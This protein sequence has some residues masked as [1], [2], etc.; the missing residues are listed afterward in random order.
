MKFGSLEF[1][2]VFDIELNL[3]LFLGF[4]KFFFKLVELI[5]GIWLLGLKFGYK[6]ILLFCFFFFESFFVI[7]L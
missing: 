3:L 1:D 6:L 7:M 4:E 2:G 5:V